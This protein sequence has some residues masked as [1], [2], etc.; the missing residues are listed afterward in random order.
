[1]KPTWYE[2]WPLHL[3]H[4]HHHLHPRSRRPV[5]DSFF[6]RAKQ[7]LTPIA[8]CGNSV[9]S[10]PCKGFLPFSSSSASPSPSRR[11]VVISLSIITAATNAPPWGPAAS[12]IHATFSTQPTPRTQ[13]SRVPIH[14]DVVSGIGGGTDGRRRVP[15][16]HKVSRRARV[17]AGQM[18]HGMCR[19]GDADAW[20]WTMTMGCRSERHQTGRR[21]LRRKCEPTRYGDSRRAS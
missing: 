8:S 12:A 20:Q 4:H 6:L 1:M 19:S 11:P 21:L 9:L 10:F 5:H 13:P 17:G 14:G 3:I 15:V 18:M 7:W 2:P 16:V